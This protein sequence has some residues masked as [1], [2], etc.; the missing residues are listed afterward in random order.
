MFSWV[1]DKGGTATAI[2]SNTDKKGQ[3]HS[4]KKQEKL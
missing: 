4:F 1:S 2:Q 3:F